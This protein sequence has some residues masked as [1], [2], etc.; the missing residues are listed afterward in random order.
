MGSSQDTTDFADRVYREESEKLIRF[1]MRRY[2]LSREVA[3]DCTHDAFVALL[4]KLQGSSHPKPVSYLYVTAKGNALTHC[5]YRQKYVKLP[6]ADWDESG[7]FCGALE[8][9]S[10]DARFV[11]ALIEPNDRQLAKKR[12]DDALEGLPAEA[13]DVAYRVF[14]DRQN[15]TGVM[16]DLGLEL[17]YAYRL[18]YEMQ[19]RIKEGR[20]AHGRHLKVETT[21]TIAISR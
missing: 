14:V 5:T 2:E 1:L 21:T 16:E 9:K 20:K 8:D 18:R 10:D 3:E 6:I 4:G 15:M 12:V 17:R 7:D 13:F 11:E 19:D